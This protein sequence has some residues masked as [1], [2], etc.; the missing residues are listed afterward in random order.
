MQQRDSADSLTGDTPQPP[1]PAPWTRHRHGCPLPHVLVKEPCLHPLLRRAAFSS[2]GTPG[3]LLKCISVNKSEKKT[4]I[5]ASRWQPPGGNKNTGPPR[6]PSLDPLSSIPAKQARKV[7]TSVATFAS[8]RLWAT[9]K[10]QPWERGALCL[11][12][13]PFVPAPRLGSAGPRQGCTSSEP[14]PN[15]GTSASR[16]S[17]LMASAHLEAICARDEMHALCAGRWEF[18]RGGVVS[19]THTRMHT[20][21]RHPWEL[22]PGVTLPAGPGCRD[23]PCPASGK[24]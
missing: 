21:A 18:G 8:C 24:E 10:G 15:S 12:P 19:Y 9:A 2:R 5:I 11:S 1:E 4:G 7:D 6:K 16:R 14:F 20:H 17:S 13:P 22:A 3:R 23:Q